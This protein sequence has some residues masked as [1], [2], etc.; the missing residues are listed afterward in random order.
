MIDDPRAT[1]SD[2]IKD[3]FRVSD[4]MEYFKR[5]SELN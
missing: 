3:R 5:S 4:S 1:H 2:P